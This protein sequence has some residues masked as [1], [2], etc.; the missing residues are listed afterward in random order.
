MRSFLVTFISFIIKPP[1]RKLIILSYKLR[2]K[3]GLEIGGPSALFGLKGYFPVYL[4]ADRVDS[5]NFSS[6][7]VWEGKISEGRTFKYFDSKTG[8]Q[9]IQEASELKGIPGESYDFLLSCHSL[10]HI[11]NP[12]KALKRWHALL[13]P[14]AYLILILPDKRNTFDIKRPYT[15]FDHLLDDYKQ[16]VNEY[17][18]THIDEILLNYSPINTDGASSK[19]MAKMLLKDNYINRYAHHHVFNFETICQLLQYC[20]FDTVYQQAASP[21]HLIT[22]ARK[23]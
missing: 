11:A 1:K 10:E 20:G 6:E 12:V 18:T 9:F 23:K 15:T 3:I 14:K 21:F 22:I 5:V 17:D 2:S 8:Y 16:D 4:F 7:T 19:E 13:K